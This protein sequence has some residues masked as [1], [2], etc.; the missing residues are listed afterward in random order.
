[1]S[2]WIIEGQKTKL[3]HDIRQRCP[4]EMDAEVLKLLLWRYPTRP[5][6]IPKKDIDSTSPRASYSCTSTSFTTTTS[7]TA[8]RRSK[9]KDTRMSKSN[10]N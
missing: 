8:L 1:M 4:A 7:T 9:N 2:D 3:R 5:M 6:L 10:I